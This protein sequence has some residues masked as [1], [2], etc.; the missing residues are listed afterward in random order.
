MAFRSDRFVSARRRAGWALLAATCA[1]PVPGAAAVPAYRSIE[2]LVEVPPSNFVYRQGAAIGYGDAAVPSGGGGLPFVAQP[3]V[4]LG[5]ALGINLIANALIAAADAAALEEVLKAARPVGA[6]VQDLDL[7]AT[8]LAQLRSLLPEQGPR[9][10]FGSDSFPQPAPV[11]TAEF[12]DPMTGRFKRAMAPAPN[13]HLLDRARASAHEAV[14]FIR[15]LPF[16]NGLQ[17][18]MYVNVASLLV[19]RTGTE[20]GE[21]VTQVMA[22]AAPAL[23]DAGLIQWWA[24]GR[25][26]RFV[27]QGLRGGLVPMV[28]EIA[29]P[30]LAAQRRKL[31]AGMTGVSFDEAGRPTDRMLGHAVNAQR[32]ASTACVLSAE[33]GEVVVHFERLR[34]PQ[35]IVGAA[36]CADDGP[37]AWSTEAVPGVAWTHTARGAPAAV[38]RRSER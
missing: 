28:E 13:Q 25:Y 21:W 22:P 24:D 8:T 33:S 4:S 26:R 19:D 2:V 17:G 7:R 16:Y 34:L 3:G 18:R 15:V 9:W 29:D 37:T 6:S 38:V 23:D 1:V 32:K 12:K 10:H 31:H 20:R 35:Q 27:L 5:A 11:P 36:Y 14:V 30:A